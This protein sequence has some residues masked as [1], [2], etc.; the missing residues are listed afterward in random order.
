MLWFRKQ[1]IRQKRDTDTSY[2]ARGDMSNGKLHFKHYLFITTIIIINIHFFFFSSKVIYFKYT[3]RRKKRM[4]NV[5]ARLTYNIIYVARVLSPRDQLRP[6]LFNCVLWK[7]VYKSSTCYW[8][9]SHKV[10]RG[11]MKETKQD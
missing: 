1:I 10:H 2:Y 11:T 6:K 4:K 8:R 3:V 9:F 7:F 5:Q